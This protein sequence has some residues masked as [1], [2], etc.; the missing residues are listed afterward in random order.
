MF[1]SNIRYQTSELDWKCHK[2]VNVLQVTD[3]V[4]QL[5]VDLLEDVNAPSAYNQRASCH[6]LI[7]HMNV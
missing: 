4:M 2:Y 7:S 1:S 6:M 5:E 3:Q